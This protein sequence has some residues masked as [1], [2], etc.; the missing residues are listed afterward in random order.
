MVPLTSGFH[1]VKKFSENYPLFGQPLSKRVPVQ[2]LKQVLHE[3]EKKISCPKPE[4][5]RECRLEGATTY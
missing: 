2:G 3:A 1:K 4:N 5:V